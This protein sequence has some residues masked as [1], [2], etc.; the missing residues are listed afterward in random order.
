[1]R[2]TAISNWVIVQSPKLVQARSDEAW[3]TINFLLLYQESSS[4]THCA[5]SRLRIQY[6][7]FSK[8][9]FQTSFGGHFLSY[10]FRLGIGKKK[11][12]VSFSY[13]LEILRGSRRNSGPRRTATRPKS[14]SRSS[15]TTT[16][17][18]FCPWTSSGPS[19][20]PPLLLTG[21]KHVFVCL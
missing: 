5:T 17:S 20:G 3:A 1:M 18:I 14:F 8:I 2:G 6:L 13:R 11:E 7:N 4:L 15:S 21:M 10:H 9:N 16:S 12:K 19:A